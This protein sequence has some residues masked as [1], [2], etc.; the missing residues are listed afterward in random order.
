MS[1][2]KKHKLEFDGLGFFK[3]NYQ[4][5]RLSPNSIINVIVLSL[6]THPLGEKHTCLSTFVSVGPS[7]VEKRLVLVTLPL[8]FECAPIGE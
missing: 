6:S 8:E 1:S 4:S 2:K 5:R 3:S 7:M